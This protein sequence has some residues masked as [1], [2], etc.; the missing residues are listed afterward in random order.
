MSPS[1]SHPPLT[2]WKVGGGVDMPDGVPKSCLLCKFRLQC[3]IAT[4]NLAFTR[5]NF[6][7]K[8]TF[9]EM[10]SHSSSNYAHSDSL[11]GPESMPGYIGPT[12][13]IPDEQFMQMVRNH[14]HAFVPLPYPVPFPVPVMVPMGNEEF[15]NNQQQMAQT[16]LATISSEDIFPAMEVEV[17]RYF[18]RSSDPQEFSASPA[19][20]RNSEAVVEKSKW[21]RF[22]Y[23]KGVNIA[24]MRKRTYTT[25][26]EKKPKISIEN[27]CASIP[28]VLN[29]MQRRQYSTN[30]ERSG[31]F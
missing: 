6:L 14:P 3:G 17:E 21:Q 22:S 18:D 20:C 29:S 7:N 4:L 12:H 8:S 5:A 10:L 23:R 2:V 26:P 30:R 13:S 16:S 15:L 25:I 1:P 28:N 31:M 27:Q 11:V 24:R 9:W 19:S